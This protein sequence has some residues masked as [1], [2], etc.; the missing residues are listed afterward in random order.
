[1]ASTTSWDV[2][3]FGLSMTKAPSNGAGCGWRGIHSPI[4]T[5][6]SPRMEAW[7]PAPRCCGTRQ[8][9]RHPFRLRNSRLAEATAQPLLRRRWLILFHFFQQLI[10]AFTALLGEIEHEV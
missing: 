1:M 8:N 6:E 10:D 5:A 9:H 3:P 4:L 2:L 7:K